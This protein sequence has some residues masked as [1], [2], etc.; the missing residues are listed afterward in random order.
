M[1]VKTRRF[2]RLGWP[3]SE[4]GAGMW[5]MVAWSG[6]D[7][8][9]VGRSLQRA[10]E[11]GCTFFDTAF[12]YGDGRSE[13][14]LG[15]LVRANPGRRLYTAT[16]IPPKNR[17]WPAKV[18]HTLDDTYPPAYVE[19]YVRLSL[20]NLGLPRVDL[21]QFHTWQ[22]AWLDD[23]RLHHTV[24]KLRA[25]GLVG[26]VGISVNR[27]EPWNGVEAV[28]QGVADAV[29]VIYNI[30][31]QSPEDQL[32]PICEAAD[33]AVVARVP[34]DEGALTDVLT[35]ASRWPKGDW[36]NRYFGA[37]NLGP[38]IER[39]EKLRPLVPPGQT[40]ASMALRFI[41]NDPV[42]ST[43]IPGMSRVSHVESNLAASASGPLPAR[44]HAALRAHRWDRLPT[45]WSD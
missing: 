42:V 25:S 36:R 34:F 28:K 35:R 31:D 11:L 14:L 40:M 23:P 7:D 43:I 26:G 4:I 19:E 13:R 20:E 5:G 39:V 3:V 21:I 8:G 30:F 32:F 2:G 41:L 9:E 17:R 37:E 6:A 12:A 18:E 33:V 24:A 38:T 22:D 45:A 44:V 16:K 1:S 15:A 27:W 10:V 29:Q